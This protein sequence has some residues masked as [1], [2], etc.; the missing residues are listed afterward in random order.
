MKLITK[1]IIH[2][3]SMREKVCDS[4]GSEQ[5]LTIHV[6]GCHIWAASMGVHVAHYFC[7][8]GVSLTGLDSDRVQIDSIRDHKGTHINLVCL[9][10]IFGLTEI[11]NLCI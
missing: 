1:K 8:W 10:L 4:Q 2:Y 7:L 5:F 9:W 3:I 11:W 6:V